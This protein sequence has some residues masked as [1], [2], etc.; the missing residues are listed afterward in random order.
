MSSKREAR[1]ESVL[2][3]QGGG[4]LGAYECG[5][6]KA[7][8][9]NNIKFDIL[10]GTSIGGINAAIIAGCK[11]DEPARSLEDFWLHL[12]ETVTP[13]FL[14]DKIRQYWSWLY[15]ATWG[16]KNMF[17]PIWLIPN[18]AVMTL[19]HPYL[20]DNTPLK[21][22]LNDYIDFKNL[23]NPSRP[24]LLITTTDIQRGKPT[25]F[26]SKIHNINENH[27]LASGGFPFYG[28]SWTKIDGQ[29]HWDGSLLSNT[30]LREVIDA[31][32][33][34]D[35]NVY[36]VN[37][38]PHDHEPIPQNM[39]ESWHRARDIMHTDKTDHNVKMSKIVTRQLSLIKTMHEILESSKLD[40]KNAKKFKETEPEYNKIVTDRGA[41]IR[42]ITRIG[43]KEDAHFLFEDADFSLV[44]I[45]KLIDVGEKDAEAVLQKDAKATLQKD[46]DAILQKDAKAIM[47][48]GTKG[49]LQKL[50]K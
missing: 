46:I 19:N 43:R 20:Y 40:E 23:K 31:S 30:P 25:V 50:A 39:F 3:M 7:L 2:V 29:Y 14:P 27:V 5:V 24:R 38:F 28:I 49:V 44:T 37:L 4:S 48:K 13:S 47:Q 22:T 6:Y 42:Q 21:K 18:L 34:R 32:P 10:A 33:K 35:K 11:N 45:K 36:I 26:D 9:K 12:A 1:P 15:S 8:E 16:N 41:V 17:Q